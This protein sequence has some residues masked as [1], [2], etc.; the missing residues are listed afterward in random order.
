MTGLEMMHT[1]FE[2]QEAA[3]HSRLARLKCGGG[4]GG[5]TF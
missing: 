1:G 4:G 3:F 2:W 5:S